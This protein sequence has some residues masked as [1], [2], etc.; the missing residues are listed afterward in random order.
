MP[1]PLVEVRRVLYSVM[2]TSTSKPQVEAA[3]D[4]LAHLDGVFGQDSHA[5]HGKIR[6]VEGCDRCLQQEEM[7]REDREIASGNIIKGFM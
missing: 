6:V 3:F 2:H 7:E 5:V 1:P 4:L